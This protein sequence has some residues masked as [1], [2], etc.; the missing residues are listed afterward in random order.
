MP[1]AIAAAAS[2]APMSCTAPLVF[3]VACP[4]TKTRWVLRRRH[5]HFL[6]LAKHLRVLHK[7]A[8]GQPVVAHL[9]R[10]L[11]EVD[12]PSYDHLQAFAVRLAAI[13]LD[14]IALA[15]DPCQDQEVLY[16]TNQLYTLLTEFLHVPTLQVQ[17]ELRSVVSAAHS[18]SR[19]KDL[20]VERLL[21]LV[22]C[23]TANDLFIFELNDLFQ[24]RHVAAWAK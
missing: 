4:E 7:A 10:T 1:S 9:L 11:L 15:M 13:R 3:E 5:S 18:Q 17:E 22:D 8:R 14:C 2:V 24:L 23:A 19:N 21:A 20:V 12:F 6:A 16:R